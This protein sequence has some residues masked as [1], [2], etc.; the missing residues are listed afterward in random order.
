M[1]P[2]IGPKGGW[3]VTEDEM[4]VADGCNVPGTPAFP[5]RGRQETPK[6]RSLVSAVFLPLVGDP[7]YEPSS[8]ESC[9]YSYS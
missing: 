4:S 6:M 2:A 9:L 7:C 5:S 8:N 1:A 3:R